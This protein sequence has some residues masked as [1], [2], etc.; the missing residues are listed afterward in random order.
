MAEK[1]IY[2]HK[3]ASLPD[4][5]F[6]DGDI[7]HAFNDRRIL[8][9]HADH[10]CWPRVNGL[11][12]GGFL[13]NQPLLEKFLAHIYEFKFMR[14][15]MVHGKGIALRDIPLM[16]LSKDD[17]IDISKTTDVKLYVF[18]RLRAGKKPL[19]G[20]PGR[21]V[22][23]GG[24]HDLS[25]PCMDKIWD[26]IENDTSKVRSN[27]TKWARDNTT[28]YNHLSVSVSDFTDEERTEYES[29]VY[30]NTDPENP[31]M[32]KMRKNKIDWK[33]HP[34]VSGGTIAKIRN[35]SIPIDFRGFDNWDRATIVQS[36]T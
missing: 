34:S 4:P 21:E 22:W 13:K 24:H 29:P 30:D 33:N 8:Q 31:I 17:E 25:R 15:G 11:K 5:Y 14:T 19:F 23:Y 9:C 6:Q 1:I 3:G 27:H 18:R 26:D 32:I 35:R 20:T 2:I 36:K 16:G 10:I 7:I 28:L 12:V